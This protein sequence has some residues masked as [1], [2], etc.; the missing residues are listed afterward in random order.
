MS[1]DRYACTPN[2]SFYFSVG[3]R[4][5]FPTDRPH[6]TL[7][8]PR[9]GTVAMRVPLKELTRALLWFRE[10]RKKGPFPGREEP[11]SY[12]SLEVSKTLSKAPA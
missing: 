4:G 7:F 10:Q 9:Q 1:P 11:L 5:A 3:G 2:E 8:A 6:E 12:D